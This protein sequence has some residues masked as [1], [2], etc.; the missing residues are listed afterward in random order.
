M[1]NVVTVR[2]YSTFEILRTT[3]HER[4]LMSDIAA[5]AALRRTKSKIPLEKNLG[6]IFD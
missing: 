5:G 2:N 4:N 3:G 6:Y 1:F